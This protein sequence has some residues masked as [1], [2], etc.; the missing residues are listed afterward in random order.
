ME[1][2]LEA[3]TAMGRENWLGILR[4][5]WYIYLRPPDFNQLGVLPYIT[6]IKIFQPRDA[7]LFPFL[8]IDPSDLSA[9]NPCN[10]LS[11]LLEYTEQNLAWCCIQLDEPRR[12]I[13]KEYTITNRHTLKS[14]VIVISDSFKY[15]YRRDWEPR[16]FNI[17]WCWSILCKGISRARGMT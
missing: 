12:Y 11:H 9:D 2:T 5:L 4:I 3:Q 6:N 13:Q 10:D 14:T 16:I 15:M 1:T 8:F 7:A 17:M